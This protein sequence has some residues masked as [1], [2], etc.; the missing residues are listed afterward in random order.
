MDA[1]QQFKREDGQ[2]RHPFTMIVSGSTGSGKVRVDNAYGELNPNVMN[3]QR[4]G[5]I[6][7]VPVTVHSGVPRAEQ[8]RECAKKEKTLL[9]LDDLLV[10]MSQQYLDALFT[11]WLTQLGHQRNFG[12]SASVQ[13]RAACGAHKFTLF[14]VNAK[15]CG[16]VA[17]TPPSPPTSSRQGL[18]T[19]L[20][21]YRDACTKNFGYLLVDM[22]PE[23]RNESFLE[24]LCK[25]PKRRMTL[26][27]THSDDQ[28]LCLVEICL[29]ILKGRVPLRPRH[30]NKLKA[31]A[32]VLRRLARTRCS[33]S[34]KK[35]FATAR[36]T[37]FPLLW[38]SLR[39]LLFR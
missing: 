39:Q 34:A 26:F 21:A 32:L 38:G 29:N 20:R 1:F 5:K 7:N 14:S 2:F 18:P 23:T 12:D 4:A 30:L 8:V 22:H 31:H 6:G 24:T 15:P 25:L 19:L 10:G 27:E 35:V 3:L 28:L 16:G 37:A 17:D 33:R 13:Q 36:R 9:V 11:P